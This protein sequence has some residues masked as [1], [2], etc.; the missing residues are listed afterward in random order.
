LR[1]DYIYNQY[2]ITLRYD[3]DSKLCMDMVQKLPGQK[4]MYW[5]FAQKAVSYTLALLAQVAG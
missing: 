4:L 3:S 1:Q 5:I 2:E